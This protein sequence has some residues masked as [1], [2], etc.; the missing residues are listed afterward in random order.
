MVM[1]DTDSNAIQAVPT[2]NRKKKELVRG[3]NEMTEELQKAGIQPILHQLD[4]ETSKELIQAIE[5]RNID[6]Q[7]ASPGDHQL[8]HAER[9]I[10]MFKNHFI[11]IL[12]GTDSS[13]PVNQWC[14]L[15][16]QAVITLNM[17]RAS[18][19]NPKISA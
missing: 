12:Y 9:A 18:R 6:Y 17:C 15:I 1:Y 3:Y 11:S 2:N 10:Q 5:D 7:I 16:W 14:R 19:I 4:N 13:F 8:N